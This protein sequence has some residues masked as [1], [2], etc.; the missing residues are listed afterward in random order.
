MMVLAAVSF[1]VVLGGLVLI[2]E[3]GH[4]VAAKLFG[5]GV[6]EFG[7]GFPPRLAS[8]KRGDTVYSLNWIPL[9]GFV[10]VRGVVGGDQADG[11][12]NVME[13]DHFMSRPLWQ[14]ATILFA[15]IAMNFILTIA[16][17]TVGYS[18]GMP[19]LTQ[20]I[21]AGASISQAAVTVVDI[22]ADAPAKTEGLAVGDVIR[23]INGSQIKTVADIR[24]Q[25][26]QATTATPLTVTVDRTLVPLQITPIQLSG[27]TTL[28]IGA[29]F[30]ESGLMRLPVGQA[31][32]YSTQQTW[33]FTIQTVQA[34]GGVVAQLFQHGTVNEAVSGPIGVASLTYQATQLGWIYVLQLAA[35]LSLNLA[36]FNVLPFP[37]LDGGRLLFV[38][39]EFFQRKPVN[40]KIEAVI[41]NIGF[42]T[43]L[44]IILAVTIKDLL[45]IF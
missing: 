8:V 44:A 30:V 25:L 23:T 27:T 31:L 37:A 4:F 16:L 29:Y 35:I 21:P 42:I 20:D 2:H 38:V 39:I 12:P 28:G 18:V 40:Q 45:H 13:R 7:I 6:D 24:A 10:K 1:I 34:L 14:R 5:V 11:I 15:G 32:V 22:S 19:S 26:A 9:G 43:L 36:I 33:S 3:L 41:H 17:F